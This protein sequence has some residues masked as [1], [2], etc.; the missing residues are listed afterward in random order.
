VPPVNPP[1]VLGGR[2][3]A[4]GDKVVVWEGSANRDPGRFADPDFFMVDR[5]PNPHLAFGHGVQFC[6]GAQLA[7]PRPSRKS[8]ARCP[9]FWTIDAF[10]ITISPK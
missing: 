5:D 3:T 9:K 1:C 8:A 7:A 6:L 2:A 4:A 10:R